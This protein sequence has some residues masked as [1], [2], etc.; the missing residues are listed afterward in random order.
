MRFSAELREPV[1]NYY[2]TL[3]LSHRR[4]F[5]RALKALEAGHG[6][7]RALE[8]PLEGC[9]RLRIGGHRLIFR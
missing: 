7:L 4:E 6:D 3:G 1:R 2:G 9:H 8:T 5:K